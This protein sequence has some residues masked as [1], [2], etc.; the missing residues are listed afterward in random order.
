MLWFEHMHPKFQRLFL[1][2]QEI[3]VKPF[4]FPWYLLNTFLELCLFSVL[5]SCLLAAWIW[6]PRSWLCI[7]QQQHTLSCFTI[8]LFIFHSERLQ[9]ER[10]SFHFRPKTKS[11]L[12][13]SK[14]RTKNGLFWCW[15]RFF[16]ERKLGGGVGRAFCYCYIQDQIPLGYFGSAPSPP[17]VGPHHRWEGGGSQEG[18]CGAVK[19]HVLPAA[20]QW[21]VEQTGAGLNPFG[22]GWPSQGA[23]GAP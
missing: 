5:T 4:V 15:K 22:L 12:L 18:F 17:D 9:R 19:S 23:P 7:P 1:D 16:L 8:E 2:L 21:S 14:S 11:E 10:L 13:C 20:P 3:Q 6:F